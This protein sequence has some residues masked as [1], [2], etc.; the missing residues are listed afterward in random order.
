[1]YCSGKEIEI[2][3]LGHIF[4]LYYPFIVF[5]MAVPP[6]GYEKVKWGPQ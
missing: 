4:E 1:M 6:A 2:F 3:T 5:Q